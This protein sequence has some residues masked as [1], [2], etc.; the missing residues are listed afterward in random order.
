MLLIH[1]G[2]VGN[3][4]WQNEAARTFYESGT[5]VFVYDY[6]G[7]AKSEGAPT[8]TGLADDARA[9]F[10]YLVAKE[11]V[12]PSHI[13]HYGVSLGTGPATSIAAS[14]HAGRT[15]QRFFP[16]FFL[17]FDDLLTGL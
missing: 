1:H 15:S 2:S 17:G 13:V 8:V 12:S 9:A 5:S 16:P 11:Y 3:I 10:D 7:Y 6:A 14:F 4:N